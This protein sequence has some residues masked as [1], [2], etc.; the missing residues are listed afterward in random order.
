MLLQTITNVFCKKGRILLVSSKDCS[1]F[2]RQNV[3]LGVYF[4]P[5]K[6]DERNN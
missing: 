6:T 3:L 4:S 5:F 1:I 2:A